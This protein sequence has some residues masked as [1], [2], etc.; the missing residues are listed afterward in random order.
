MSIQ[1]QNQNYPISAATRGKRVIVTYSQS[2]KTSDHDFSKV[3]LVSTVVLSHDIPSTVSES[4]YRANPYVYLEI[5][6][7]EPSSAIRSAKEIADVLI[8]KYESRKKL[9]PS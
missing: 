2:L 9:R 6:S 1:N 8:K 7:A 5:H 3:S 4:F